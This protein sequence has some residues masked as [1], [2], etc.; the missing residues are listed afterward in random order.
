M[1]SLDVESG[2]A[3][4]GKEWMV[5]VAG[6][7]CMLRRVGGRRVVAE[8]ARGEHAGEVTGRAVDVEMATWADAVARDGT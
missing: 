1:L 6:G 5:G 8:E 3:Q 2:V 7:L 4:A